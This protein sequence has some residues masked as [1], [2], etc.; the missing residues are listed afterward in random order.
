[1][2]EFVKKDVRSPFDYYFWFESLI[3]VRSNTGSFL[4]DDFLIK[5]EPELIYAVISSRSVGIFL[6]VS[7]EGLNYF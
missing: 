7:T 5:G 2:K 1:M 6:S 4:S 3:F